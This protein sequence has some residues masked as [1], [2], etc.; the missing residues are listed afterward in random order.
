MM[1]V[2]AYRGRD[3]RTLFLSDFRSLGGLIS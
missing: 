1:G 3:F 2:C